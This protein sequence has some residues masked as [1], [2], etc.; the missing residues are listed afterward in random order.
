MNQSSSYCSQQGEDWWRRSGY[1]L[2]SLALRTRA[3]LNLSIASV[4]RAESTT[5]AIAP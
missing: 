5:P 2:S 4:Q 1:A 3:A